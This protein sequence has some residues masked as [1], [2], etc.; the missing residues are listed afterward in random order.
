MEK[1]GARKRNSIR[2]GKDGKKLRV[3]KRKSKR[4]GKDGK[5]ES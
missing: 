4:N 2:N 5:T 3:S 1:L